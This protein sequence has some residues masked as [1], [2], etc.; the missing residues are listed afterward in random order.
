MP[1][2]V[3]PRV[4]IIGGG[5]AGLVTAWELAGHGIA[6][7]LYERAA[8]LGGRIC[9]R[10]I[11]GQRFDVGAESFA[12]RG[13]E[14]AQ[15]IDDLGLTHQVQRPNALRSWVIHSAIAAPLPAA[16]M[17][18]IPVAPLSREA[19]RILGLRGALRAACE[20]LLPSRIGRHAT[21]VAEVIRA[22]FGSRV[23]T[24][25][26]APVVRGVYS[27]DPTALPMS[28]IPGLEEAWRRHRSLTFAARAQRQSTQAAGAAV[29]SLAGGMGTL[30]E[31]LERQLSQRAVR[32]HLRSTVTAVR[33]TD[34]GFLFDVESDER[35]AV[36]RELADA[37][38]VTVPDVQRSPLRG[39]ADEHV[40]RLGSAVAPAS[41]TVVEVVAVLLDDERLN[42]A[43][44]GTGALVAREAQAGARPIRA[45]AL[46]HS[47]AKWSWLAHSF[48]PNRHLIRL[49][50][51]EHSPVLSTGA[52]AITL[53]LSDDDT[54]RLACADASRIL[55][56][57][58]REDQVVGM[59]RQRHA[60]PPRRATPADSRTDRAPAAGLFHA[61]EW[62]SGT[63]LATVIPAARSV[64]RECRE[65][66][67]QTAA[68]DHATEVRRTSA[69][70]HVSHDANH[71]HE[72]GSALKERDVLS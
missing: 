31:E 7:D 72:V 26:V 42:V 71:L 46:T 25:L 34:E 49:S 62:V 40:A 36:D 57:P 15:L 63:G 9:S 58:V 61:G 64:A 68:E 12:L 52:D 53:S 13:G 50:Y 54:R 70:D 24:R 19:R 65:F 59:I 2:E 55:G 6:V 5:I 27:T 28:A 56:V 30:V 17:I 44:R 35:G 14:V 20:P 60:I 11:L 43:P 23:L 39:S 37:V 33:E 47:S 48:P 1:S 32:V 10:E 41:G 18:G 67:A 51:G 21:S 66:L 16:G 45:K 3:S 4:A 29:A 8:E 22:R 69:T 38:I